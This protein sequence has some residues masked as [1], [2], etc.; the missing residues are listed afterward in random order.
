MKY[1]VFTLAAAAIALVG[2]SAEERLAPAPTAVG[3]ID[4]GPDAPADA[5]ED[6]DASVPVAA[7]AGTARR[8]VMTRSPFGGPT[9]NHFADGDFELSTGQGQYGARAFGVGSAGAALD[10]AVETGGLCRTG[11][12]CAIF[13]PKTAFLLRGAAADLGKG[14]LVSF[15]AKVPAGKTCT[16]VSGVMVTCDTLQT[17]HALKAIDPQPDASGWCAYGSRLAPSP[18]ALC[19]YIQN[20]LVNDETA[21]LDSAVLG[22]DDGTVLPQAAEFFVPPAD[23]VEELEAVRDT[24]QRTTVVGRPS[25]VSRPSSRAP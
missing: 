22:P 4:A 18:S 17:G 2:C 3:V 13:A 5:G 9:A 10:F 16:A 1:L 19:L 24:I 20:K 12:R 14:N 6:A 11:L 21:L 7:D 25:R 15:R 23:L 8:T